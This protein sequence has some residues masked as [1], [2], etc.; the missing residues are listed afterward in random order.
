MTQNVFFFLSFFRRNYFEI[1]SNYFED[2]LWSSVFSPE[3]RLV[4][5][6]YFDDID[7]SIYRDENTVP[8]VYLLIYFLSPF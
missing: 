4:P 5:S 1:G 6:S 3:A 2:T 8:K 7:F